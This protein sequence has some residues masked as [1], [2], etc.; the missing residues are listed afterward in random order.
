MPSL[1]RVLLLAG[2]GLAAG[3]QWSWAWTPQTQLAIAERAALLAPPDL[4]AQIAKHPRE[5]RRGALEAFSDPDPWRHSRDADGA[6]S[7]DSAIADE[8][9]RAVAVIEAHRPFAEVVYQ[10]GRLAHYVADASNPLNAS[11]ADPQEASYF[12]DFLKYAEHAMPRF[13]VVFYGLD[14]RL[15]RASDLRPLAGA[16]LQRSRALYPRIGAEYR[17]VG[18]VGGVQLFDDRSTAFALAAISFS[19]AVSDSANAFR[20]VW[21]RAGGADPRALPVAGESRLVLL[22]PVQTAASTSGG[23]SGQVVNR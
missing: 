9:A 18:R 14:G 5:F 19:H 8:A 20:Y 13:A 22:E 1:G 15:S 21:L 4:R 23:A 6:G 12:A 17:R 7:L 11:S 10:L 2:A 16:A 3:A